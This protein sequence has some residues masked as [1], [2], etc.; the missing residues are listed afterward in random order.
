M[1]LAQEL[2]TRYRA[3]R[4]FSLDVSWEDELIYPAYDGFSIANLA[5]TIGHILGADYPT[6]LHPM[7]GIPTHVD[8]VVLYISD[9]L[10]YLRLQH[11]IEHDPEVAELVH[12]LT[13]GRGAMPLTSTTPSTT[14]A[15]LNTLWT[16]VPPAQHG[17]MGTVLFLRELAM[18]CNILHFKPKMGDLP[19]G[20]LETWG[21][22]PTQFTQVPTLAQRLAENG[23]STYICALYNLI[24]SGLSKILHTGVQHITPN[25]GFDDMWGQFR[26]LLH[27][28]RGQKT[29]VSMYNHNIDQI[30]HFYHA[31]SPQ[32][33]AEIKHQL[34]QLHQIVTD[35]EIADG[36]T[37]F[38]FVADHGHQDAPNFI[39]FNAPENRPFFDTFRMFFGGDVRFS[40]LYLRDGQRDT[41]IRQAKTLFG[42]NIALISSETALEAGLFG[43]GNHHPEAKYRIGDLIAI[44]RPT[45]RHADIPRPEDKVFSLHAGLSAW[46]M[47]VPLLWKVI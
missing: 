2:L 47:L 1:T 19:S 7:L 41:A 17:V 4:P 38:M 3:N 25:L 9:G 21:I 6:P 8:R 13:D 34:R 31:I 28:T 16:G 45:Y 37:L 12:H 20:I 27:Q 18:H 22:D 5:Q 14:V 33:S 15:A 29:Y 43:R 39:Q 24:G 23:V 42:E 44:P 10:G 32:T 30:S 35:P 26:N 36:R 46:E 11:L 40:Y